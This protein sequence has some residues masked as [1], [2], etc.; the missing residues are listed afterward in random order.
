LLGDAQA[1]RLLEARP[2]N[3]LK[4]VRDRAI[5]S[6][7]QPCLNGFRNAYRVRF[8]NG[9]VSEADRQMSADRSANERVGRRKLNGIPFLLYSERTLLANAVSERLRA[10]LPQ[11]AVTTFWGYVVRACTIRARLRASHVCNDGECPVAMIRRE[12]DIE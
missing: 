8:V 11:T 10:I 4:G 12:G 6:A 9:K 7:F 5:L 1:R 2:E 3:T